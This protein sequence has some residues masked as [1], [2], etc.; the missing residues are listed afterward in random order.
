MARKN[1]KRCTICGQSLGTIPRYSKDKRTY[2]HLIGRNHPECVR[3]QSEARA[4]I[5]KAKEAAAWERAGQM[6]WDLAAIG[7]DETTEN[8]A[9]GQ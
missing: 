2:N 3:K 4:R 9:H 8:G 6:G 1:P 5:I 7:Y